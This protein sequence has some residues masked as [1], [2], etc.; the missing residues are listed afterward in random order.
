MPH[1]KPISPT[2]FGALMGALVPSLMEGS[3]GRHYSRTSAESQLNKKAKTRRDQRR[4]N[5]KQ[6]RRQNRR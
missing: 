3:A 2:A 5:Q 4:K 1:R 6:A